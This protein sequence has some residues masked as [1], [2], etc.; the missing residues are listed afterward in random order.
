MAPSCTME[1][2]SDQLRGGSQLH[3]EDLHRVLSFRAQQER[4]AANQMLSEVRPI[5]HHTELSSSRDAPPTRYARLRKYFDR[6]SAPH[7]QRCKQ[8]PCCVVVSTAHFN[9]ELRPA[10]GKT[11]SCEVLPA[12]AFLLPCVCGGSCPLACTGKRWSRCD[13]AQLLMTWTLSRC[14]WAASKFRY[15]VTMPTSFSKPGTLA[16]VEFRPVLL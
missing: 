14:F 3:Q 10:T 9:S 6:R 7:A 8:L 11:P 2:N 5:I 4:R 16:M 13:F 15:V 12:L 1:C